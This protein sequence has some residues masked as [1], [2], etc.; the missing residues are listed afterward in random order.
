MAKLCVFAGTSEGRRLVECLEGRGAEIV[1][2]VATEYG[3]TLLRA[4]PGLRV[5]PGRMDATQI[6]ALLSQERFDAVVEATHP[7]ACLLYTSRCV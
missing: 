2:C 6:G 5:C 4:K 3:G 7:Y 1:A